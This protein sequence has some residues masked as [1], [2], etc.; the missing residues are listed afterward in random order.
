[1]GRK[2]KR[3]RVGEGED[4]V[5]GRRGKGRKGSGRVVQ[6]SEGGSEE[7]RAGKVREGKGT[8]IGK[9]GR[10]AGVLKGGDK[11]RGRKIRTAFQ[12]GREEG[13]M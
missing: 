6:V 2:R 11:K 10:E 13:W 3:Q 4:W 1:M 12:G 8:G 5:R 7:G 9:D